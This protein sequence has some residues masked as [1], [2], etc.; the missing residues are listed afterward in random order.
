MIKKFTEEE[1]EIAKAGDYL[2][3]ECTQCGQEFQAYKKY[4]T[5]YMK[6]KYK[7]SLK[8][9]TP[10]CSSKAQTTK[11]NVQCVN[12]TKL[13]ER[14]HSQL[15][16]TKN[17]FCSKSCAASFNNKNKKFGIRRSKL[18]VWIED[19]LKSKYNFEIIFNG[20]DKINSE[21]D[22]YIPNLDLAFELN[23][24]FH[25]EPIFGKEKLESVT[26]NDNRKYQACLEKNIELCIIDVSNSK[27]FSPNRDAKYL[28][29][30]ENIIESKILNKISKNLVD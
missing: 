26:N 20:K 30:I 1:L 3:F 18:E 27:R 8:Y 17:S 21:L 6:G 24:I 14:Q 28:D 29:I 2:K 4:Y 10:A 19:K 9:C 13:V 25:Y 5:C 11:I 12:C 16:K 22:I 15:R 23:G 7:G